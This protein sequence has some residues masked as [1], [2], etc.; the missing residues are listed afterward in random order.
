MGRALLITGLVV[1]FVLLDALLV[2]AVLRR[3]ARRQPGLLLPFGLSIETAALRSNVRTLPTQALPL[4]DA[5]LTGLLEPPIL[6]TTTS[7]SSF[8]SRTVPYST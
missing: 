8:P 4:P 6:P 2:V 5:P 7:T 3:A 1:A